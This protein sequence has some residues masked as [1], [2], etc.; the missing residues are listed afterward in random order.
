MRL[1]AADGESIP[2]TALAMSIRVFCAP[3]ADYA[4]EITSPWR[5]ALP[6]LDAAAREF[7]AIGDL[8]QARAAFARAVE[9]YASL[10]AA[11]DLAQLR[12]A[13]RARG[14]RRG[15]RVRRWWADN[16]R[17]SL[18]SAEINVAVLVEEW[19]S[20]PDLS[21][22]RRCWLSLAYRYGLCDLPSR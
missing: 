10:G 21:S 1:I 4:A 18:T 11:A 19:R 15:L 7:A 22:P 20:N 16:G 9:A 6:A 2:I 12:A 13:F 17:D 14:I 3:P 5:S 8:G